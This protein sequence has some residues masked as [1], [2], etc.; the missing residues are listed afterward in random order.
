MDVP[1]RGHHSVA[2]WPR[3]SHPFSWTIFRNRQMY[4]MFVSEKEN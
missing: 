4:S 2:R 3:N 1:Q